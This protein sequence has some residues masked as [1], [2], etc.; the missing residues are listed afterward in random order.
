MKRFA[1]ALLAAASF[2]AGR[3][4][5]A[6]VD[7]ALAAA[8]QPLNEG[9]P[10][11]TVVRLRELLAR[12]L[13]P[14]ERRTAISKL[15][16]ALVSS[17]EAEQALELLADPASRDVP[18]ANFM[19]AQALAALARWAEALPLYTQAAADAA[20]PLR[21]DALFGRAEALRALNRPDEALAAYGV[22]ERDPQWTTRARFRTVELLV[23]KQESAAAARVLDSA[24]PT[25]TAERKERRL[26]R[27]RVEAQRS[28]ARANNLYGSI[29]KNPQGTPH[30]VLIA[31]LFAVAEAHLQSH[32]PDTGDD[33]LEDFI[34]HHP[35]DPELG[36]LFAKLDQLYAAERK[37]SRHELVRWSKDPAQPRQAFAQWYLARANLRL[38]RRDLALAGFAELRQ[39]HPAAGQFAEA[40]CENAQL[41]LQDNRFDEALAAL[42]AA[43]PLASAPAAVRR[44]EAITGDVQYAA[45]HF[46]DAAQ[47]FRRLARERTPAGDAALV[48]A[49]FAWLEAGDEA[50]VAAAQQ[51]LTDR[52]ADEQARGDVA[53]ERGLVAAAHDPAAAARALQEFVREFPTHPRIA[54]AYV[55]LAEMAFHASPPRSDEARQNLSRAMQSHPTPFASERADYLAIWLE[56]AAAAPGGEEKVIALANEFLQ[57][58][59]ASPL[60]AE[61]RLKLAE[62]HYRR[63]D[64]ANAQ[65]QFS[66]LARQNADSPL[67]EQAL[68]FA[69]QSAARSMAPE[70]LDRALVLFDDVVKRNGELK[71][72]ARNEQAVLERKLGKPQDAL[73]LYDEVA[74]GNAKPEERREALCGRADVL[75]ELGAVDP[76]NYR[77]ALEQYEQLANET[78]QTSHW[79]NQALFKKGICQEKLGAPE[80][81]LATLYN[82]IDSQARPGKPQEYFWFY[83]AG[84]NAAR[85]L[86]QASKWQPAAVIYEKL[87]FAGGTRSDEAKAR[88]DRLRLEHFLWEQ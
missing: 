40:F 31:A 22:V 7:P 84:F 18:N 61:V 20:S 53:L 87:A 5:A 25:T 13:A 26:L 59:P 6:E 65:T 73:T 70:S 35:A 38:G 23:E 36:A 37:Q 88:L 50:H 44:I 4:W 49:S 45:A 51:E 10:Q 21:A 81:A 24:Q 30:S 39:S 66:L 69:G 41:L 48:N 77:R 72:A 15:A 62:T 16:E 55:A 1:I 60:R 9:V 54:E 85:L 63:Q 27:G 32:T 79:H 83:K 17:G 8:V 43:R 75:Y 56:D 46:A 58:Y 3:L 82:V 64:F 52:N 47:T 76:E 57:K 11:V 34:E 67:A 14:E 33:F 28:R 68:F 42:D 29:L 12:G 80:E 19:E 86:E 78:K 71:W 74:K 2:F